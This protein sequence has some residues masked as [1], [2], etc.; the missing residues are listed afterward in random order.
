MKGRFAGN[1]GSAILDYGS[2]AGVFGDRLR[3]AGFANVS[4]YD[5]FSSPE[6]PG[7][8]FD[9]ITCFEVIE[10]STDPVATIADMQALLNP[11]G[12]IV[13]S[14]ALQPSDIGSIR[15]NWWY[16][17]PRNGHISFF[18]RRT[19]ARLANARS[20]RLWVGDGLFAFADTSPTARSRLV[21]RNVGSP[22]TEVACGAPPLTS[23]RL[24]VWHAIETCPGGQYRWTRSADIRFPISLD[25]ADRGEV[26]V[27]IPTIMGVTPGFSERCRIRLGNQEE[28]ADLV[29][30][31]LRVRFQVEPGR[32]ETVSLITPEPISPFERDGSPD[33]RK[34]G[35]AI[36]VGA[37]R[38]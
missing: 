21:L 10:H 7:W 27:S 20:L 22:Y 8:R 38:G 37:S 34:L 19:L 2:G 6:R 33:N 26:E 3:A 16:V 18:T 36:R 23:D 17:A 14:Q 9:V 29:D 35:I 5:P 30:G 13:L 28:Q 1:E 15:G 31:S 12:C 25:L 24:D 32:H 4:C 11:G